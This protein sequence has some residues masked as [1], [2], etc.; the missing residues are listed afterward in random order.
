MPNLCIVTDPSYNKIKL[1][2][3]VDKDLTSRGIFPLIKENNLQAK[4]YLHATPK[5]QHV[6]SDS[7]ALCQAL[8]TI[9]MNPYEKQL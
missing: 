6:R 3:Q 9:K 7:T 8:S 2:N 4:N 1:M 5:K